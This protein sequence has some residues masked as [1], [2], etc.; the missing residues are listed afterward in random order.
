[1]YFSAIWAAK[2]PSLAA[3]TTCLNGVV[4]TSPAAKIPSWEVLNNSSVIIKPELSVLIK[5]LNGVDAASIPVKIN[6][7]WVSTTQL[8]SKVMEVTLL[9]PLIEITFFSKSSLIF[10]VSFTLLTSISCALNWFLLWIRVT[11]LVIFDR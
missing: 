10:F 9:F 11:L 6:T 2:A 3:V 5:P 8:S 7:P 4:R 1:M